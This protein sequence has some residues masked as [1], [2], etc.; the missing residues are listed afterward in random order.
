MTTINETQMSDAELEAES[1]PSIFITATT[2]PEAERVQ[3]L[4]RF[5][6]HQ[7]MMFGETMVYR[8]MERLAPDY[9]GGFW[10]FYTLSNDAYY[11]APALDCEKIRICCAG[12][13]YEGT[14]SPDAAGIVASL[15]ALNGLVWKTREDRFNN[16]FYALRNYAGDHAEGPAIFAAID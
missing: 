9:H 7:Y 13:F 11:M 6:G 8:W 16:L 12:N 14:L 3:F 15:Y 5:F 4:P 2:V 10:D 1:G